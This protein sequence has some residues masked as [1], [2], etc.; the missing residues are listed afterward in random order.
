[1]KGTNMVRIGHLLYDSL[2]GAELFGIKAILEL[3]TTI[4]SVKTLPASAYIGYGQT[5][6]LPKSTCIG[7]LN[8]GSCDGYPI[9]LSNKGQV[10]LRGIQ[11]PIVGMVCMDQ[12]IVDV[13]SVLDAKAGDIVTIVGCDGEDKLSMA[14]IAQQSCEALGAMFST[15]LKKPYHTLLY[16]DRN[17]YHLL[18]CFFH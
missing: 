1:M 15:G 2:P 18:I 8:I 14:D 16:A 13:T 4:A 7:I 5:Y 3:K 12:C 17:I 10:L 6:R 9:C 11:V